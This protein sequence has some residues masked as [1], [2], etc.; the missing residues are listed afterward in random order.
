MAD[1]RG[2]GM[3]NP[4]FGGEFGNSAVHTFKLR[5][6]AMTSGDVFL[7]GV[8]PAGHIIVGAEL[9]NTA[10]TAT[11]AMAIGFRNMDGTITS[12]D[13]GGATFQIPAVDYFFAAATA[14]LTAAGRL[15]WR[16]PGAIAGGLGT[17][18]RLNK[19]III[20]GTL[21]VASIATDTLIDVTFDTINV[22]V[23]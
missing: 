1:I 16:V 14:I 4:R 23:K 20:I 12:P 19:D 9:G 22:G 21:S 13:D 15:R 8:I 17:V 6:A 11:A 5:R 2:F 18:L 3:D 7:F 10:S